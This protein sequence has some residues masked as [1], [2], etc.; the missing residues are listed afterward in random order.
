MFVPCFSK[1][2][3][4]NAY[5]QT[6]VEESARQLQNINS[7]R[8][9]YQFNRLLFGVETTPAVLQHIVDNMITV[10]SETAAY[11]NDIVAGCASKE[12]QE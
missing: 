5:F 1:T 9:Q 8:G 6:E 7:R 2:D 3:L 4:A 10:I 11:L 12:L